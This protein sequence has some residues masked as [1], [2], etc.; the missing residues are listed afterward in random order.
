MM[1]K[2]LAGLRRRYVSKV[3]T[4]PPECGQAGTAGPAGLVLY[5]KQHL[6]LVVLDL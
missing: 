1:H 4:L 5:V 3:G 6:Y 2:E